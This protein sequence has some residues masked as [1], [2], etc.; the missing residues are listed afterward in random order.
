MPGDPQLVSRFA[1]F[2]A[3][4]SGHPAG[5]DPGVRGRQASGTFEDARRVWGPEYGGE[6]DYLRTFM[7]QL[8]WKLKTILQS[9]LTYYRDLVR[10]SIW[11]CISILSIG[12]IIVPS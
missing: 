12:A 1:C 9:P 10:L 11:F 5:Q 6:V 2:H 4:C 7:Y 8:R 3:Y